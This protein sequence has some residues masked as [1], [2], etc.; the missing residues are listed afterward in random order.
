MKAKMTVI[1][2]AIMLPI[3]FRKSSSGLLLHLLTIMCFI[4]S[5]SAHAAEVSWSA[6]LDG[7]GTENNNWEDGFSKYNGEPPGPTDTA[8]FRV[9]WNNGSG[10]Y[11][12]RSYDV[13]IPWSFTPTT[14]GGMQVYDDNVTM[15]FNGTTT[16]RR[17][18]ILENSLTVSHW[19]VPLNDVFDTTEGVLTLVGYGDLVSPTVTL[20]GGWPDGR[21]EMTVSSGAVLTGSSHYGVDVAPIGTLNMGST[22]GSSGQLFVGPITNPD[23]PYTIDPDAP[24]GIYFSDINVG[25]GSGIGKLDVQGSQSILRA[26]RVSI[27]TEG[28]YASGL[29]H[30]SDN[31]TAVVDSGFDLK[32]GH[33]TIDGGASVQ[34]GAIYGLSTAEP[35]GDSNPHEI[36]IRGGQR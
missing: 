20:G 22:S 17:S 25:L 36:N 16:S 33:L 23:S 9:S 30:I 32:N 14:A 34:A 2:E 12:G 24:T 8:V 3:V 18:L 26:S 35:S 6:Y 21:G 28:G 11:Y 4:C 27:G 5:F 13:Y 19:G 10:S 1:K 31:A 7:E 15:H 29:V